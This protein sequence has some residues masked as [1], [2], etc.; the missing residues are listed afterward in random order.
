[1]SRTRHPWYWNGRAWCPLSPDGRWYWDSQGAEWLLLPAG[2]ITVQ[3]G[4]GPSLRAR[5]RD[6]PHWLRWS[7]AVWLP[8]FVVW[9]PVVITLAS[10]HDSRRTIIVVSVAL[11]LIAAV[12][13]C[14]FGASLGYRRRWGYLWWSLLLGAAVLGLVIFMAFDASQPPNAPS[15]PG[16]GI[17]AMFVT[18]ALTPVLALFLWLGGGIGLIA[19]RVRRSKAGS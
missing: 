1:V 8:L 4:S 14:L 12:A 2:A 11:G 9:I 5:L 16:L 19:R 13:T 15:D 7:W 18:A 10:H 17:G 3:R 6:L